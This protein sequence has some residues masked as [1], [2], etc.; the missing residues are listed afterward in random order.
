[1]RKIA[2]ILVFLSFKSFSIGL[3][4]EDS[5]RLNSIT[6]CA[7]IANTSVS[8]EK[9]ANAAQKLMQMSVESFK[10]AQPQLTGREY[11]PSPN[12]LAIDFAIYYQWVVSDLSDEM[13]KSILSNGW[14]PGPESWSKIAQT[15][16]YQ[17]NCQFVEG[18]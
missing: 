12:D 11:N 7:F 2:F 6:Q 17:K 9:I 8:N 4:A 1:M 15:F 3:S 5:Q 18:K 10:D 13:Y 14:T 16:Y